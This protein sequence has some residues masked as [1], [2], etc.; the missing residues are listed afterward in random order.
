[1]S[2]EAYLAM[3][4]LEFFLALKNQ[5]KYEMDK[6][7]AHFRPLMEAIRLQTYHQVNIQ[8][9]KKDKIRNPKRLMEF[10]WDTDTKP[11]TVEGMKKV[12]DSIRK[13][14]RY[15]KKNKVKPKK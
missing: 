10:S 11:Q 13:Y 9:G 12:V 7:E 3:T 14:Y 5:D 1:M 15:K 8:L 4:P 6:A 2:P